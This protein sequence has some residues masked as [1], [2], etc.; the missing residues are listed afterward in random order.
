MTK[1]VE[2]AFAMGDKAWYVRTEPVRPRPGPAEQG[3]LQEQGV[4]LEAGPGARAEGDG[5]RTK[6]LE[7][8]AR[9]V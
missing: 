8:K 5:L 9:M 7:K 1:L 4:A 6:E 3:Q 2:R